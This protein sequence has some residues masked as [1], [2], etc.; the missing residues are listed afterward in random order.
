MGHHHPHHP[1]LPIIIH[2]H[3]SSPIITHHHPSPSIIH[4]HP[5]HPPSFIIAHHD[6]S[7]PIII[8]YASSI[9]LLLL[10]EHGAIFWAGGLVNICTTI[11]FGCV[12]KNMFEPNSA[13]EKIKISKKKNTH[14]TKK[15]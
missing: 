13:T 7:S 5:H 8:H 4:H 12:Q 9:L 1:P 3:P 15:K 10:L 6:P 2:C 14:E 11:I